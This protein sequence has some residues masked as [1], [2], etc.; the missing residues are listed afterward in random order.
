VRDR[1]ADAFWKSNAKNFELLERHAAEPRPA[2]AG[3]WL[4]VAG[5]MAAV[6]LIAAVPLV[7]LYWLVYVL[8]ARLPAVAR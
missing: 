2:T 5:M 7:V 1:P 8:F 3:D 4:F 6:L